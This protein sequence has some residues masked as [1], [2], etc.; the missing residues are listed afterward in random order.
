[1]YEYEQQQSDLVNNPLV[2]LFEKKL[3][4][5]FSLISTPGRNIEC[6]YILWC[7]DYRS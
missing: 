7:L 3:L 5:T 2:L 4:Q 1:M 6:E